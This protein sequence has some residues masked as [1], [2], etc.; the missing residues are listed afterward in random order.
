MFQKHLGHNWKASKLKQDSKTLKLMFI[1]HI[2]KHF[3]DSLGK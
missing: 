3:L 1:K 2:Q